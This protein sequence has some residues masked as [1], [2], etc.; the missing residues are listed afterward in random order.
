MNVA[1][2]RYVEVDLDEFAHREMQEYI[3]FNMLIYRY[4]SG[5]LLKDTPT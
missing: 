1:L 2:A 5:E 4:V 3:I